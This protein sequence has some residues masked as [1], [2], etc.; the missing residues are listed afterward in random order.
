MLMTKTLLVS[1]P[2]PPHFR[3][4]RHLRDRPGEIAL[5]QRG[6]IAPVQGR[7]KRQVRRGDSNPAAGGEDAKTLAQHGGSLRIRNMLDQV[8][9]VNEGED[10]VGEGES[11][12]RIQA[13]HPL[14]AGM[15]VGIEPTVEVVVAAAEMQFRPARSFEAAPR[16]A[17][18]HLPRGA[19]RPI[20]APIHRPRRTEE[21]ELLQRLLGPLSHDRSPRRIGPSRAPTRRTGPRRTARC[22]RLSVRFGEAGNPTSPARMA[23]DGNR[24]R[25]RGGGRPG[26]FPAPDCRETR[27]AAGVAASVRGPSRSPTGGLTR[28]HRLRRRFP[29]SWPPAQGG[30]P[31][32]ARTPPSPRWSSTT[33]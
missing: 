14:G 5:L 11:A 2:P 4:S 24:R 13:R 26:D 22:S 7:E 28:R 9:A 3:H 18:I 29:I 33:P 8:F 30:G 25:R 19:K 27:Y 16:E 23:G 20:E 21:T 1:T 31:G 10:S 32:T 12:R 17:P 6:E 15:E